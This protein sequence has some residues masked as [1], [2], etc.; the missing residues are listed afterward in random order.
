MA[1]IVNNNVEIPSQ[2][3]I[4]ANYPNPFNISTS[5]PIKLPYES[6]IEVYIYNLLGEKISVLLSGNQLAGEYII[7]WNGVDNFNQPISSGIYFVVSK[8]DDK[9]FSQKIMLLK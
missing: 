6:F 3:E 8:Y 4:G 2:F 1:S 7:D 5:I 9:I